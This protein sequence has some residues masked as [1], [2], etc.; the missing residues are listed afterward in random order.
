MHYKVRNKLLATIKIYVNEPID[1]KTTEVRLQLPDRTYVH[2]YLHLPF[3]SKPTYIKLENG[4][5]NYD[6]KTDVHIYHHNP[7]EAVRILENSIKFRNNSA[8]T[9]NILI[10][11]I[12]SMEISRH[13]F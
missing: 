10:N 11:L 12:K 4:G 13:F 9:I 1:D 2:I 7:K 8:D 6:P 3:P 5:F